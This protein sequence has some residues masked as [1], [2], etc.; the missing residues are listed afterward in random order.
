MMKKVNNDPIYDEKVK[1]VLAGLREGKSREELADELGYNS[2]KSLDIYIRRRNFRWDSDKGTYLPKRSNNHEQDVDLSATTKAAMVITLF[3]KDYEPKDVARKVGFDDH[4]DL[5]SFM[6]RQGFVWSGEKGN[7]IPEVK[8]EED[9]DN[10]KDNEIE[11]NDGN[12]EAQVEGDYE[13]ISSMEKH[14]SVFS[15][16]KILKLFNY[17]P[18]LEYLEKNRDGLDHLLEE[19]NSMEWQLPRFSV[20]G[21]ATTKNIYMGRLMAK[22]IEDFSR[23]NGIS[24]RDV[25]EGALIEY[26]R[27]YGFK[28]VDSILN[29]SG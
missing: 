26:F 22:M 2:Y 9:N 7:Y 17:L 4:R 1:K 28:H 27:K 16:E 11:S 6:L 8:Q 24:Q 20:K 12:G 21:E 23:E 3:Q 5:A 29:G 18:L 15:Q 19:I 10:N 14:F 25:V 13:T